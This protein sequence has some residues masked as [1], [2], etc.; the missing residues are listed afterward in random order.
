MHCSVHAVEESADDAGVARVGVAGRDHEIGLGQLL[1]T[2]PRRLCASVVVS[3]EVTVTP[4][5]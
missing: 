5:P 4:S 3:G 2:M 1:T